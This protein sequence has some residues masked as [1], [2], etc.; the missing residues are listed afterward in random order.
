LAF[1]LSEILASW[2]RLIQHRQRV[3]AAGIYCA[4]SG[5]LF[6]SLI[7]HWLGLSGYR[8]Q[9]FDHLLQSLIVFSPSIIGAAAAFVLAPRFSEGGDLE[10]SQHYFSVASWAYPLAAAYTAMTSLSDL[11][12]PTENTP[13]LAVGL[14]QAVL[15]LSLAFTR[16]RWVH[17]G[18]LALLWALVVSIFLFG[19]RA[20]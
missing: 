15:L 3:R 13:S 12:V 6:F 2:S 9:E 19:A 4:A 16:R 11:L 5:W 1:A 7:L 20:A 8:H 18:V 14:T 17:R 10:I